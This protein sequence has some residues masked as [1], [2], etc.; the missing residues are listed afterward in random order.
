MHPCSDMQASHAVTPYSTPDLHYLA[1]DQLPLHGLLVHQGQNGLIVGLRTSSCPDWANNYGR[2]LTFYLVN[3]ATLLL[4]HLWWHYVA[5]HVLTWQ[6]FLAA[7]DR[8]EVLS[9]ELK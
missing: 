9:G 6:A 1:H 4:E 7:L 2:T 5:K 3:L 8:L